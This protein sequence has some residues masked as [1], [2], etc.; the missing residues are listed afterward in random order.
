MTDETPKERIVLWEL[1]PP[2]LSCGG[3]GVPTEFGY[4][5]IH[6]L[7]NGRTPRLPA[8]SV[9]V[10]EIPRGSRVEYNTDVQEEEEE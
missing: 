8:G 5:V 2:A 1:S 3:F 7:K 10:L 4:I 9:L 6:E